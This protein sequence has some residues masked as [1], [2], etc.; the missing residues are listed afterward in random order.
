MALSHILFTCIPAWGKFLVQDSLLKLHLLC[1]IASESG[2]ARPLCILAAR[3]AKEKENVAVSLVLPP[4]ILDKANEE[5]LSE[6]YD[7]DA[8]DVCK[9]IRYFI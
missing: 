5:I 6:L 4:F 8:E 2:H 7:V 1:M 3:L 9:R